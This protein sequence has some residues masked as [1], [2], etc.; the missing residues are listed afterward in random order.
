MTTQ[1]LKAPFVHPIERVLVVLAAGAC[2]FITVAIW[3]SVSPNQPMWLLP[4]LYFIEM[5]AAAILTA[6]AFLLGMPSSARIAW[7]AAGLLLAFALMG[8][9][10]VGLFYLPISV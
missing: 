10:S 7:V 9:F 4:G 6:G 2:L 5:P 8:A 3:R 1:P